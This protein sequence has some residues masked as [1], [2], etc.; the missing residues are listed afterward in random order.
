MC[1]SILYS[2]KFSERNISELL[3]TFRKF[4]YEVVFLLVTSDYIVVIQ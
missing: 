2:R 4:I 1:I 3:D